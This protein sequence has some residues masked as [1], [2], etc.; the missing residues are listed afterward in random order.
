MER[1]Q[2]PANDA[3][4]G[5]YAQ[6]LIESSRWWNGP[7]FLWKP[8]ENQ[9]FLDGT[10]PFDVSPDD[11]EVR[12]ISAM[13]TQMQEP[14]SLPEHLKYFSSWHKAKRAVDDCLRLQ[15]TF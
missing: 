5:L 11:P 2:N 9:S 4:C 7:D 3:S 12:K 10:E 6:N 14:L 13:T 15:K 1:D 8:L